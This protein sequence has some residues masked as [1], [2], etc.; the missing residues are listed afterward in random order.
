MFKKILKWV[1]IF[2]G[3]AFIGYISVLLMIMSAFGAFDRDYTK[4]ELIEHYDLKRAEMHALKSYY[5]S[6]VPAHHTVKIE[7]TDNQKLNYFSY[8]HFR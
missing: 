8:I 5:Q 7:F 2:A 3:I 4:E 1:L 6:I